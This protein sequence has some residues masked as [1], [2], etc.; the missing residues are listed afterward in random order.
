MAR[1][2]SAFFHGYKNGNFR[3]ENC[4]V[5]LNFAQNPFFL[6]LLKPQILG[7]HD[8]CLRKIIGKSMPLLTPVLLHKSGVYGAV[9][10]TDMLAS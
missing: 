5:F 4:D 9:N 1:Q 10:Y 3:I 8:L 6:F 7:T 2:Y